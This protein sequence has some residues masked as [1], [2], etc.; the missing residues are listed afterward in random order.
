M[1]H[2]SLIIIL[3]VC[4]VIVLFLWVFWPRA[5]N[6]SEICIDATNSGARQ[7]YAFEQIIPCLNTVEKVTE[8]MS[9]NITYD[10]DYDT[11]ER[12]GNEYTPAYN[13]YTRGIDDADGYAILECYILEKND[14]DAFVIGLSIEN[15]VG[16]NVC[17]IRNSDGTILT[18]TGTEKTEG[19]FN[20]LEDT[21][22]YYKNKG[23]MSNEGSI[24]TIKASQIVNTT[25]DNTNP[26]V[27][28]LP[29]IISGK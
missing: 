12:G 28:E 26:S 24:R 29:W 8:F 13:I 10:V 5:K 20:T 15:P 1:K 23:W 14:F 9:N 7:K 22:S 16:S 11:R 2:R 27:L 25:T 21:A 17:G 4:S 3:I 18:L 6:T 19:P